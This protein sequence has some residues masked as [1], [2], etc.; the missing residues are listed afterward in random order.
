MLVTQLAILLRL[1]ADGSPGG[2]QESAM[3]LS[4]S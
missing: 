4:V 2:Q 3:L 1:H